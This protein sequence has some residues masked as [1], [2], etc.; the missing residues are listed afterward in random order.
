[1]AYRGARRTQPKRVAPKVTRKYQGTTKQNTPVQ[2]ERQ[3]AVQSYQGRTTPVRQQSLPAVQDERQE[4]I[5]SQA[6]SLAYG[7]ANLPNYPGFNRPTQSTP[8]WNGLFQRMPP[9]Q[10]GMPTTDDMWAMYGLA[11]SSEYYPALTPRIFDAKR[12]YD[13][14]YQGQINRVASM[15][16]PVYSNRGNIKADAMN[17]VSPVRPV[18][19]KGY[20]GLGNVRQIRQQ[21][22]NKAQ[23]NEAQGTTA[24]P[25]SGEGG[26]EGGGGGGGWIDWGGG[27]GGGSYSYPS[28]PFTEYRQGY[29]AEG[30][31]PK[32]SVGMRTVAPQTYGN[33][34]ATQ[35]G[36]RRWLQ[37]LTN[38]RI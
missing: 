32:Q 15:Y 9:G 21:I 16:S 4:N 22:Y 27:G 33:Q 10:G 25:G 19:R 36:A 12:N 17:T 6:N 2:D 30:T 28:T 14:L 11:K 35:N 13:Q 23:G 5:N 20:H 34:Y 18:M 7:I 26:G 31:Q 29:A 1:M 8:W 3:E 38:W 24:P 37:L